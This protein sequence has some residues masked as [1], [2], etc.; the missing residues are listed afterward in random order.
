MIEGVKVLRAPV[1]MRISKG[2][3]MPTIGFLATKL[4]LQND[5][6]LLHLPQFDAPG[7]A[8]RGRFFKKP[9]VLTYHCDL[10]LPP[11]WFNR[12]VNY[13]V[14]FNNWVAARL[15]DRVVAYTED[16]ARHS[17]LVGRL[18]HKVD[19]VPPP[20]ILPPAAAGAKQVFAQKWNLGQGP[21]IGMAARLATEK[22]AEVLLGA[23]PPILEEFPNT[24]V[25]YAG[26]HQKVLGEEDYARRLQPL[27][28][29]YAHHWTFLGPLPQREMAAFYQN[30]DLITLPSLNSTESFGLVQIEA[31][32]NGTPAV[33]SNLPGV[34]Q[35]VRMTGMGE[36]APIGDS[37]GLA[38]AIL[39]VLRDKP[40]YLRPSAMIER[41]FSP[42][43]TA[44]R[45][46]E[47]FNRLL[48]RS[49]QTPAGADAYA[50]LRHACVQP[51]PVE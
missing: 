18:L 27:F 17:H 36:I 38:E 7:L 19:I 46:E 31:M 20:V 50:Q 43:E 3:I 45:Y 41:T 37:A 26:P 40:R 29:Q 44:R 23:L 13:A 51:V 15:T 30:C 10:K 28:E 12:L 24:R 1:L 16:Y 21:F 2:V 25:L 39:K 34:R 49:T 32:L 47:L 14:L 42:A 6:M 5:V 48:A 4:T 8:L 22:G 35:P 33:A 9:V 11:G